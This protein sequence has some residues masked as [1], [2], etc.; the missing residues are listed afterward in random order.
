MSWKSLEAALV[1]LNE[2]ALAALAP[3]ASSQ[4]LDRLERDV[5][6]VLPES[7]RTAWGEHDGVAGELFTMLE[8]LSTEQIAGEWRGLRDYDGSSGGLEAIADGPVRALWTSTAWIP[9]VLIGGETRHFCLD[10][11]PAPGGV[12]GQI[13][14]A[15]PKSEERRVVAPDTGAFLELVAA[16]LRDGKYEED[17]DRLDVC[18]AL[19]I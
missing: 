14:H 19:G 8:I 13:I 7:F 2:G 11:D 1:K 3:G 18:D 6:Q 12:V 15:S 5:R 9:I 10:L 16:A 4:A 17:G